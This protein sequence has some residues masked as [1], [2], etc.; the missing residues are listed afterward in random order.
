MQVD[1]RSGATPAISP[2][3]ALGALINSGVWGVAGVAW[4]DAEPIKVMRER[5]DGARR[6]RRG[7]PAGGRVQYLGVNARL[8]EIAA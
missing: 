1:S 7:S 3:A 2:L 5:R 8:C 6:T 4:S